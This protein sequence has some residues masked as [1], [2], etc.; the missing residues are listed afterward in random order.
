ME[1]YA[2]CLPS[3]HSFIILLAKCIFDHSFKIKYFHLKIE[4]VE[5]LSFG[6]VH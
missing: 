6:T 4:L 1:A 2:Q 3:K 5:V